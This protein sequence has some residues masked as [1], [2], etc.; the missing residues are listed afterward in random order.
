MLQN[1]AGQQTFA[2]AEFDNRERVEFERP[3]C[4]K[5]L[6]EE[7]AEDRIE[8]GGRVEIAFSADRISC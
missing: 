8:I 3:I 1:V 5:L 6:G 7:P 2:G 4:S